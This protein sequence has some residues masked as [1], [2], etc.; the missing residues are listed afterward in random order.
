MEWEGLNVIGV[1]I[2]FT[3]S[4]HATNRMQIERETNT[5]LLQNW[6]E[7]HSKSKFQSLLTYRG[8]ILEHFS[9]MNLVYTNIQT[10]A[11]TYSV[12]V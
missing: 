3:E 6:T 7:Y 10:F 11:H 2:S 5:I 4:A 1:L 9:N 8:Q 12:C